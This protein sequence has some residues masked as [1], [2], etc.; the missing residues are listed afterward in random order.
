[1]GRPA[2]TRA[3]ARFRVARLPT[4]GA[5]RR[6][7]GRARTAAEIPRNSE[8]NRARIIRVRSNRSPADGRSRE[9]PQYDRSRGGPRQGCGSTFRPSSGLASMR[10][11]QESGTHRG[12][13]RSILTWQLEGRCRVRFTSFRFPRRS[14]PSNRHG[15]IRLF[16]DR[17]PNRNRGSAFDG[18][19]GNPRSLS[20]AGWSWPVIPARCTAAPASAAAKQRPPDAAVKS[21]RLVP[22][23]CGIPQLPMHG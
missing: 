17:R 8:A 1:M 10:S 3:Q 2:C 6:K 19:R 20:F 18:N 15:A 9:W 13:M 4:M 21:P 5:R 11:L 7:M 16:H 22:L 14:S 12:S 23:L